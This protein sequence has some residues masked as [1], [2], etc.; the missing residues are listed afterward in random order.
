M[1]RASYGMAFHDMSMCQRTSLPSW[2][3]LGI[4]LQLS[5]ISFY[6]I[7]FFS[8]YFCFWKCSH[9]FLWEEID[10][11]FPLANASSV[12]FRCA[13]PCVFISPLSSSPTFISLFQFWEN[14]WRFSIKR[15]PSTSVFT[16]LMC[17][18]CV[19][20]VLSEWCGWILSCH[21]ESELPSRLL[22]LWLN[23]SCS[24]WAVLHRNARTT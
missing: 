18:P 4:C 21:S 23:R 16:K 7:V 15:W 10:R 3:L 6:P 24:C 1:Q 20:S 12:D 19:M 14:E 8:S 17:Y 13:L 9:L 11:T 22:G 2:A 5:F